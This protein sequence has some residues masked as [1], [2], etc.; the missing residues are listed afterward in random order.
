MV[1][2]FSK[3]GDAEA[4]ASALVGNGCLRAAGG[5]PEDKQA[6]ERVVND[7]RNVQ[8]V[9]S[10]RGTGPTEGYDAVCDLV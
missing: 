2:C 7:E 1:F 8:N 10:C 6:T 3:P 4:F 5:D 9:S